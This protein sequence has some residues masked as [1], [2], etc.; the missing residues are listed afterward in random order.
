[1]TQPSNLYSSYDAASSVPGGSNRED[2]LNIIANVAPEETPFYS[3]LQRGTAKNRKHE[4]LIDRLDTPTADNKHAEGA[5]FSASA[6]TAPERKGNVCQIFKK[7]FVI[8]DTQETVE[9]AG[10]TSE[11]NYEYGKAMKAIKTDI[12]SALHANNAAVDTNEAT[13]RELGGMPAW[14]ETNVSRGSG[15]SNGADGTTA[16]TDGTQRPFTEDLLLTVSQ[17]IYDNSGTGSKMC[18]IA[19]SFNKRKLST[20]SGNANVEID[21]K[22]KKR[23]ATVSV[24]ETDFGV[25]D[26]KLSRHIRARE[27]MIV[28]PEYAGVAVLR[29]LKKQKFAKDGDNQKHGIVCELT[30]ECRNEKAHGIV[31]DL[32]TS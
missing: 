30:L 16:A 12:D 32:T 24:F 4:W 15:G 3:M 5:D 10:R 7:E 28:Q 14:L 25:Y 17:S 22:G 6:I 11:V 23:V 21:A 19:N 13:A 20:F 31:A 2:L 29:G 8:S 27:V 18:A 9:K 1:M 26:I